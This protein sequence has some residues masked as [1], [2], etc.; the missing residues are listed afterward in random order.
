MTTLRSLGTSARM[1]LA[2]TLLTGVV[3]PAAITLA[4]RVFRQGSLIERDGRILGSELIGQTF[5]SPRYFWC[6]PSA[7]AVPYDAG[8]SS[9]SNYGPM[10]PDHRRLVQERVASLVESDPGQKAPIP[11]DLVTASGSGLDPHISPAA[12]LWQLP[13]VARARGLEE[14]E[15]RALLEEH[16]EGRTLGLL[17][18]PRVNVVRLNLALDEL[19]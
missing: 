17:G 1:L 3:Y 15:L 6:R 19:R 14:G 5:T 13:R 16:V 7:T 10:N 2:M 4:A 12:A 9:G 8:A 11:I 18:E